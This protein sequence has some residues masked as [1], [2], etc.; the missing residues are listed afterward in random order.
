MFT[1]SRTITINTK[2]LNRPKTLVEDF[3]QRVHL[4]SSCPRKRSRRPAFAATNT[5][6]S[7]AARTSSTS[8]PFRQQVVEALLRD[9]FKFPGRQKIFISKKWG[10]T[11]YDRYQYQVYWDEGRLVNDG[12]GDHGPLKKW[13]THDRAQ[14]ALVRLSS[15]S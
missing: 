7:S 9:K 6:S 12:C 1:I 2:S 15:L 4:A 5:W 11:K 14:L 13:E 3:P 8:A 10:F